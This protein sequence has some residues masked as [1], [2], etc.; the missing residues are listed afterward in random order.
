MG[1]DS[2]LL[3]KLKGLAKC[4]SATKKPIHILH[5]GNGNKAVVIFVHGFGGD[6]GETWGLF[7]S[8][9]CSEPRVSSWDVY[10]IGYPSSLRIDVPNIWSA[11]PE[12]K[13]LAIELRTVLSLPPFTSYRVIAI[14]AHSMGGLVVQRAVL[15]EP[16]LTARVSHL[17]FFGTPSGGLAKAALFGWLKRQFRDMAQ[18]SAFMTDLR[19]DWK[20]RYAGGCP[21]E[22]RVVAGDRDEFVSGPSSLAP[23]PDLTQWV[24][25]GSHLAIVKP[26]GAGDQSVRLVVDAL[27]GNRHA[28]GV[29]DGARLA[30]ERREFREAVE[31]LLPRA[32]SLDNAGLVILALALDGLGRSE[33]SLAIL[34]R[35][36]QGA[37]SS[38]DALGTLAGRLKRRWLAE[39]V[40]ADLSR[41]RELYA[42]GLELATAEVNHEQA[43]YHA[44]NI[45]FLDL[46][47]SP[48]DS[49]AMSKPREMA[50]L[51]KKHCALA[52]E[53]FWRIATEAEAEL[54][55]GDLEHAVALY[56]RA[57]SMA[58]SPRA[59]D[60]MYSQAIRV[61]ERT[62][63]KNGAQRIQEVF[64][65]TPA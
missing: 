35:S 63:G 11:D 19:N 7:P 57:V 16:Q 13:M 14:V 43:Y 38:S 27:T 3:A 45:A 25:P 24:V 22:L 41:A 60:S 6:A 39:R 34:D 49:K 55:L 44:I 18:G 65:H 53:S 58:E 32:G 30:V 46:M 12:L 48:H 23:F 4:F 2:N 56:A 61:A 20:N 8:L 15:D 26:N 21:F 5:R 28:R 29:V 62:H 50:E 54:I 10:S 9:I 47:A 37:G 33:E 40:A 59:I 17:I 31:A 52:P 1:L 51:S 42:R 36:C 64:L